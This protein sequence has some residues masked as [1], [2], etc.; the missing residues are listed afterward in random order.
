MWS[1]MNPV[2]QL[3]T[4]PK[5]I[6]K[7][8]VTLKKKPVTYLVIAPPPANNPLM[9]DEWWKKNQLHLWKR[10]TNVTAFPNG[11]RIERYELTT[12]E[13]ATPFDPGINPGLHFR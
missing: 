3:Y 1:G 10:P 13:I 2:M 12:Q 8:S 11:Y 6:K 7:L 4:E 5:N 9:K